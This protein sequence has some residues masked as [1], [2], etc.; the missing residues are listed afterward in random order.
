VGLL[1]YTLYLHIGGEGEHTATAGKKKP[2]VAVGLYFVSSRNHS[3][4][5]VFL[6]FSSGGL[7]ITP[8]QEVCIERVDR[9]RDR[10][11][12]DYLQIQIKED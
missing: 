11:G 3:L 8:E 7:F 5:Y 12:R 4:P 10:H 9:T 6:F 2:M 1:L